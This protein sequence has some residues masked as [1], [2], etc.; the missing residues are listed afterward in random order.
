MTIINIRNS[1]LSP[2]DSL[3]TLN[4]VA[5]TIYYPNQ[6]PNDI[7][8]SGNNA[9]LIAGINIQDSAAQSIDGKSLIRRQGSLNIAVYTELNSGSA[10]SDNVISGLIEIYDSRED[11]GNDVYMGLGSVIPFDNEKNFIHTYTNTFRHYE[12]LV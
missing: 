6:V 1:I 9:Y 5:I 8:L 10:V 12:T 3:T 11:V 2:L 4:G 7:E